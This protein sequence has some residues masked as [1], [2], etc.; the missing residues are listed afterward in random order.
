MEKNWRGLPVHAVDEWDYWQ[1]SRA[2]Y[3][4][5]RLVYDMLV[6]QGADMALVLE[7]MGFA[8]CYR[9]AQEADLAAGESI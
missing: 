9:A 6:L 5:M 1:K 3:E 2:D 4:H 7:M 8:D